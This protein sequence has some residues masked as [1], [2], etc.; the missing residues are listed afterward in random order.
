MKF[1]DLYHEC[2]TLMEQTKEIDHV[3]L[4]VKLYN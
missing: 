2:L 3:S 1:H 4:M